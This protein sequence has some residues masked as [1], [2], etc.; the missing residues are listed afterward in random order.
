LSRL[1]INLGK[2]KSVP[3]G[4]VQNVTELADILGCKVSSLPMKYLGLPLSLFQ[5]Q[6]NMGSAIEK[7]EGD[8]RLEEAPSVQMM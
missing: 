6:G 5:I 1:K 7:M 3:I 2:S 8:G 4:N